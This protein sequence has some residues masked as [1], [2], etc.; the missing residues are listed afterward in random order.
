MDSS[1]PFELD[2]HVTK[3]GY[4]WGLWQQL[5]WTCRRVGFWSQLWKGAEVQYTFI[6][7]QRAA[8]YHALLAPEPITGTTLTKVIPTYPIAGSVQDYT[9]RPCSGMALMPILAKWGTYLQQHSALSTS[10]LSGELQCL[11][12]PVTYTNG[13][14]EELVFEPLVAES[15]Y[16]EGKAP[17]PEDACYTDSSSRGQPPE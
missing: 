13:M 15:P 16:Q 10:P 11:L 5:E 7:K 2:V 17:I 9:Q 8:V 6:G 1:R 3:D 14:Q 4:G 12:G